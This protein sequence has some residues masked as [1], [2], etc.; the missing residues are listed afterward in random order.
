MDSPSPVVATPG[1][2]SGA[3][4]AASQ[5][6]MLSTLAPIAYLL[7][8]MGTALTAYW[9]MFSQFAPYDDSGFFINSIRL[10]S[11]GHVLY[12]RVWTDYGP[13]SYEVWGTVFGVIGNAV[14]T[15][16]ARLATIVV[17]LLTSLLLGVSCQRLTGRLVIGVAVQILSFTLLSALTAEPMHA[18][19]VA[20]ALLAIAV[21]TVSFVLPGRPRAALC[22]LGGVVAALTLTKVNLGG[23]AAIAVAY[24]AVMAL[25]ALWR[26]VPL[27]WLAYHSVGALRKPSGPYV[28]IRW[29]PNVTPSC[30][31]MCSAASQLLPTPGLSVGSSASVC[32][33]SSTIASGTPTQSTKLLSRLCSRSR[34]PGVRDSPVAGAAASVLSKV[35]IA[36][37][38]LCADLS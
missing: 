21:A 24:A 20:C 5:R 38:V 2:E 1:P 18:S 4:K 27:R 26:I 13:F 28:K 31:A 35:L 15:D 23:F 37:L 33:L 3:L 36:A 34:L 7:V 12:D 29:L 6:S 17:W 14:S 30:S 19:G 8:L 32:Q 16:S 22:T 11:Q 10:F 9:K 25:H